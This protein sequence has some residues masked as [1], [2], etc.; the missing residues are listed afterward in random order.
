MIFG[1]L[2]MFK[3]V[4]KA[5]IT[6][7]RGFSSTFRHRFSLQVMLLMDAAG[8][9]IMEV[10][11]QVRR[12]GAVQGVVVLVGDHR[13][14]TED[15][16]LEYEQ[17]ALKRGAEVVK[18]SLGGTTL[19][20]GARFSR[21]SV[22][23]SMVFDGFRRFSGVFRSMKS[24]LVCFVGRIARHRDLATLSRRAAAPLRGDRGF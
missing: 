18:T 17:L 23:F 9:P 15:Q 8:E 2:K 16:V 19:L 22:A 5:S 13:S 21:G 6:A 1:G 12:S 4:L 14:F 7:P 20:G 24:G 3:D 11:K 10:L